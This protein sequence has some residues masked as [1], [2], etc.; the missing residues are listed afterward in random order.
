[1]R[2]SRHLGE[3][4]SRDASVLLGMGPTAFCVCV[5]QRHTHTDARQAKA[6]HHI[7]FHSI[8][9]H[10]ISPHASD[11]HGR[12]HM[13]AAF[14]GRVAVVVATPTRAVAAVLR[15]SGVDDDTHIRPDMFLLAVVSVSVAETQ[16][17]ITLQPGNQQWRP[18]ADGICA[19]L[20]DLPACPFCFHSGTTSH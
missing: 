1:M 7:A 9:F 2:A 18:H 20:V 15:R 11:S 16:C 13:R 8:P 6:T 17:K 14:S 4:P 5:R 19:T 10:C 3:V 12:L